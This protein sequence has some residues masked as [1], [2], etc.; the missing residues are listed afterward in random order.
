MIDKTATFNKAYP[1]W[2]EAH[3]S[4]IAART[5]DDYEKYGRPL[6]AFFGELRMEQIGFDEV[7][8]F[9][10]WRWKRGALV[11]EETQSKFTHNAETV[12]IKNEINC[13]LKPMLI[14]AGTW[15]AIKEKKFKHLPVSMIGSGQ[16]LTPGQV[17]TLL[18]IAFSNRKWA[19]AAHCLRLMFNTG[20][21][22]GEI[23]HLRRRDIDLNNLTLTIGEDG[24]KNHARMRT[25]PL[26]SEAQDSISYLLARWEKLGGQSLDDFILPHRS[27]IGQAVFSTP[28]GGIYR[29]WM[30]IRKAAIPVLGDK[31]K[32]F[33][34]YDCR[35]TAITWV[36]SNGKV[37][38]LTAERLFGHVSI[39][40]QR[41]YFKP[42]IETMRNAVSFLG[43]GQT[44]QPTIRESAFDNCVR[45]DAAIKRLPRRAVAAVTGFMQMPKKVESEG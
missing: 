9:Q 40:M 15:S 22:F 5:L 11:S 4:Y 20:C 33:R 18:E 41:R 45:I 42:D 27:E 38:L 14:Q 31:I 26:T 32:T 29:S 39:Q 17:K 34:V 6:V 23:R 13:V 2:L 30:T 25:I 10:Q 35:V 16:A 7:R 12:R 44:S 19:T 21:G 24:A 28:M 37:S 8:A 36:L 1:D 3:K 43:T